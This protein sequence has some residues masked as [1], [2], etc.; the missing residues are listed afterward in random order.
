MP[1]ETVSDNASEELEHG[2]SMI[3]QTIVSMSD[4]EDA[5]A[6]F[7]SSPTRPKAVHNNKAA[8]P[9]ASTKKPTRKSKRERMRDI[10]KDDAFIGTE[11]NGTETFT[12]RSKKGHDNLDDQDEDA[13]LRAFCRCTLGPSLDRCRER[14]LGISMSDPAFEETEEDQFLRAHLR[15]TMG[16]ALDSAMARFVGLPELPDD[17]NNNNN[18][19]ASGSASS[20]RASTATSLTKARKPAGTK[21]TS[22]Q[23]LA[24]KRVE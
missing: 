3:P 7:L 1:R 19:P 14:N 12:S 20:I 16:P 2:E 11:T 17:S 9:S 6:E 23:Y 10:F 4:L 8:S 13:E 5:M 18:P 22:I 24:E 15:N 21:I